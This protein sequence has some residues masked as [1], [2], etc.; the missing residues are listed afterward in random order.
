M[1]YYYGGVASWGWF[2]DYHYAPRISGSSYLS[3]YQFPALTNSLFYS[4][5]S[6]IDEMEFNFELGKPFK[7]FEQLMGVLPAA[8]KDLIPLAYQVRSFRVDESGVPLLMNLVFRR[9]SCSTSTHPS[10]TSTRPTSSRTLTGRRQ[11]GRLS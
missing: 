8:S 5:L 1:H 2:Y 6:G 7:P 11:N 10:S 4:D 3:Y 9:T